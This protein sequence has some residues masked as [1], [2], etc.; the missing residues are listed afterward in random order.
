VRGVADDWEAVLADRICTMELRILEP[1]RSARYE[2]D[3]PQGLARG[4]YRAVTVVHVMETEDR[5]EVTSLPF[6]VDR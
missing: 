1:D 5:L 2:Y 3:L 6:R 4:E